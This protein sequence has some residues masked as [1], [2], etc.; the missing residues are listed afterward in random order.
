V[1]VPYGAVPGTLLRVPIR[2][3]KE[4]SSDPLILKEIL[5]EIEVMFIPAAVASA[6]VSP[7]V[8]C[9]WPALNIAYVFFFCRKYQTDPNFSFG[10][11]EFSKRYVVFPQTNTMAEAE[12]P[13]KLFKI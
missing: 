4:C 7:A 13:S 6:H 3:T 12:I 8:S 11:A 1:Q 2:P 9:V 5:N 10:A